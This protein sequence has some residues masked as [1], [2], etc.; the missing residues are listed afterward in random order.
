MV[1]L[2]EHLLCL[3]RFLRCTYQPVPG[4]STDLHIIAARERSVSVLKRQ[5]S[6]VPLR[7]QQLSSVYNP[8]RRHAV[9]VHYLVSHHRL[10]RASF[11]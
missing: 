5:P 1:L 7:L 10:H 2:S 11:Y 3:I 8:L 9:R 4:P 6:S